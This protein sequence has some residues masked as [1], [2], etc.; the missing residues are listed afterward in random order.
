MAMW[1]LFSWRERKRKKRVELLSAYLDD[2]LGP[3]ERERLEDRLA[4]EPELRAEL[5]SLCQTVSLVSDLPRV[6]A[7]RNFVLSP[8]MVEEERPAPAARS[9]R[10]TPSRAWLLTAATAV[11][12][13]LF[14]AVLVGDLL[15]PSMGSMAPAPEAVPQEVPQVAL[16]ASPVSEKAEVEAEREAE[17]TPA[18][19]TLSEEAAPEGRGADNGEGEEKEYAMEATKPVEAP[20]GAGARSPTPTPEG[21]TPTEEAAVARAPTATPVP[22]TEAESALI[23]TPTVTATST[24]P[25]VGEAVEA[26][27]TRGGEEVERGEVRQEVRRSSNLLWRALEVA[28]GLV[29]LGLAYVTVQVWR[30]RRR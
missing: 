10:P 18:P 23:S 16:D 22:A 2:R 6:S 8:S 19:P 1:R 12:S 28:L 29:T 20:A 9:R 21:G 3:Q 11:A 17:A 15:L 13:L 25:A 27:P 14:I 30:A 4:E 7:P 24:P 5:E 26:T